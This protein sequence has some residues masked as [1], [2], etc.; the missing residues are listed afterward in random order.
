M[1]NGLTPE[2][3]HT[4]LPST[5]QNTTSY[6]LRNSNDYAMFMLVQIYSITHS[7]QPQSEHGMNFLTKLSQPL[8]LLRSS[9]DWTEIYISLLNITTQ[10]HE[11]AKLCML[12]FEWS[13]AHSTRIFIRKNIVPSPSC[14]CGGFESAYYFFFQCPNYSEARRRHLPNNLND[15]NTNQLLHGL[16]DASNTE[17]EVLFTQVQD[18]IVHSKK[19][20]WVLVRLVYSD[21]RRPCR[22]K[23]RSTMGNIFRNI[24]MTNKASMSHILSVV[25]SHNQWL[26]KMRLTLF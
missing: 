9:L 19:Y 13:A 22:L 26:R 18:F 1:I 15:Y 8:L 12:G 24:W 20:L 11:L 7:F 6:N 5:V 23:C 21:H 14:S 4:L 25:W 16:P 10:D 3:L 17:N 2:Y